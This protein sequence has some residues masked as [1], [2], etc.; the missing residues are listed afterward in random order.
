MGIGLKGG[1][2]FAN[3]TKVSDL[4]NSKYTGFVFGAF[5]APPSKSIISSRT[6]LLYSKQGYNYADQTNTGTVNLK[7]II[8]PQLMGINITKFVQLQVGMQMAYL[9]NATADQ[10][11]ELILMLPLW[12][13]II[14]L[15][16]AQQVVLKS[17]LSKT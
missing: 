3:V 9:L 7:Y 1:V 17:I 2:N 13:I 4:N 12:I 11:P 15:I 8:L 6:E 5:L 14:D 16:M 10:L